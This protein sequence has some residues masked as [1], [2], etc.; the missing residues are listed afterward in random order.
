ME[1]D[2]FFS[3]RPSVD[4]LCLAQTSWAYFL[5][6]S[7]T[8]IFLWFLFSL[9]PF[10]EWSHLPRN[11]FYLNQSWFLFS[12]MPDIEISAASSVVSS[13]AVLSVRQLLLC[14]S[15]KI[16]IG[17]VSPLF[18][19]LSIGNLFFSICGYLL[20]FWIF[21]SCLPM[22]GTRDRICECSAVR[23]I[24]LFFP[25]F[26]PEFGYATLVEVLLVTSRAERL[27][28]RSNRS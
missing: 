22:I 5:P 20:Y 6:F 24:S 11:P 3:V 25:S 7:V 13:N 2:V 17:I 28:Q 14:R 4:S 9:F 19:V 27:F 18:H 16:L 8:G 1:P 21:L 23:H 10:P 26:I 12:K 15:W